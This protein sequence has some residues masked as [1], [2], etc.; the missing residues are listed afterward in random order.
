VI[1]RYFS[2]ASLNARWE[3]QLVR[4]CAL[5]LQLIA[6]TL[7]VGLGA[8]LVGLSV[9][10]NAL[11]GNTVRIQPRDLTGALLRVVVPDAHPTATGVDEPAQSQ[12]PWL[13]PVAAFLLA[14]SLGR[15]AIRRPTPTPVGRAPLADFT[16]GPPT[17][18]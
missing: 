11:P 6:L 4:R 9:A 14:L 10:P 13:P 3:H 18:G 17:L 7:A 5:Y 12:P 8:L 16:R 1:I 15:A 2:V